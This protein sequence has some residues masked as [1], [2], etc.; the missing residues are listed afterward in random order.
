ME[1][2]KKAM[3]LSP[4]LSVF[5]L[6]QPILIINTILTAMRVTEELVIPAIQICREIPFEKIAVCVSSF[7]MTQWGK[8]QTLSGN[9]NKKT[10]TNDVDKE[11]EEIESQA[12]G[13]CN[14]NYNKEKETSSANSRMEPAIAEKAQQVLEKP[15]DSNSGNVKKAFDIHSLY[16]GKKKKFLKKRIVYTRQSEDTDSK[17]EEKASVFQKSERDENTNHNRK[18]ELSETSGDLNVKYYDFSAPNIKEK[19][20]DR[21]SDSE[22]DD[23]KRLAFL[24][25]KNTPTRFF[26]DTIKLNLISKSFYFCLKIDFLIKNILLKQQGLLIR[27]KRPLRE[28]EKIKTVENLQ[29]LTEKNETGHPE[30]YFLVFIT[31][32]SDFLFGI[33]RKTHT[34]FTKF[35]LFTLKIQK[36]DYFYTLVMLKNTTHDSIKNSVG[37]SETGRIVNEET[38]LGIENEFLKKILQR[39]RLENSFFEFQF[40]NLAIV[41]RIINFKGLSD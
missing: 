13:E 6:G 9:Y 25:F 34:V 1:F 14:P 3:K 35:G 41:E 17:P 16:T 20:D 38:V 37:F 40:L 2:A 10:S 4:L 29:I 33:D 30:P 21:K 11:T 31:P 8:M 24:P 12:D 39:L 36:R 26:L 32:Q 23:D 15:D 18:L 28:H 5:P 22:S 27:T 19:K 7:A